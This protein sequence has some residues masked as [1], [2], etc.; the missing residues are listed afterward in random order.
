MFRVYHPLQNL[1]MK[2]KAHPYVEMK[3]PMLET[4][5]GSEPGQPGPT[6]V[7]VGII[8]WNE[9]EGI[10]RTLQSLFQQSLFEKLEQ[11]G[12]RCEIVCL[13]NG[14]TDQTPAIAAKF[15]EIQS[16]RHPLHQSFHC[17]ALDLK[18]QG[19][20]N[21]WNHFVH[22]ASAAEAQFLILMDADILLN[23]A[24]TLWNLVVALEENNEASIS[25]DR[26]C[27]SISF[28][29]HKSLLDRLSLMASQ[30]THAGEAQLCGQL[31]CIRSQVAR[32][33]FLPRHLGS[34]DDGFIKTTVCTDFF[35]R[36]SNPRRIVIAK[37]S[38]HTFDAYTSI[39]GILKNQK[40]QM[41]GQTI[42]H[43]LVDQYLPTLPPAE[44]TALATTLQKEENNDPYWLKRLIANHARRT[45]LFW[46]IYPGI[47]GFRFKRLA[48]LKGP[49]K[50]L[51]LPM[52]V[53]G[54]GVSMFTCFQAYM[55]LR[56]GGMEY[57]PHAKSPGFK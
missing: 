46:R 34:C 39:P 56:E 18:E 53:C 9:A 12:V 49:R 40:R 54:F 48:R 2:G 30:M 38:S 14:C 44:R 13:A 50:I 20:A 19:K 3:Q 35:T 26:P 42:V 15:F 52:A 55:T 6:H 37:D 23:S 45:K 27:K 29:Q 32:Q 16:R 17:C 28:K 51:L 43:V 11:R 22:R 10:A 8:A 21:A 7:S 24:D 4:A 25:T 36:Q 57:W 41:I 31:Y 47:A 1:R 5:A 33:I